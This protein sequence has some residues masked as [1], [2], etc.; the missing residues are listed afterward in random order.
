MERDYVRLDYWT[1]DRSMDGE[2]IL[3]HKSITKAGIVRPMRR[4]G[5]TITVTAILTSAGRATLK[6]WNKQ[7]ASHHSGR[8]V[9]LDIFVVARVLMIFPTS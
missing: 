6:R 9:L 3:F 1:S 4:I 8:N 2:F 5:S 7:K